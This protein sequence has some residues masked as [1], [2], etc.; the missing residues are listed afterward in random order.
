MGCCARWREVAGQ[1]NWAVGVVGVYLWEPMG[2]VDGGAGRMKGLLRA[3]DEWRRGAGRWGGGEGSELGGGEAG[4]WGIVSRGSAGA[5]YQVVV[6]AVVA[7]IPVTLV[8]GKEVATEV[9]QA[10]NYR[11]RLRSATIISYNMQDYDFWGQGRLSQLLLKQL[12]WGAAIRLVTT[13]PPGGVT[14]A[15]FGNKYA[16]LSALSG[17]G[18]EVLLNEKLHAK[19]YLFLDAGGM[20]TTVVGS[21]NL[22]R[23]GFGVRATPADNLVECAMVCGEVSVLQAALRFVEAK[24]VGDSRTEGYAT[25]FSRHRTE[26]RDAG[27]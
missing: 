22:T 10:I 20:A 7:N 27:L 8:D 5:A 12:S 13:P 6:E 26:I 14:S 1:G 3:R 25:W 21:A 2:Y 4:A 24:I 11:T 23:G 17:N 15:G 9:L 19:A 18:G 16:L